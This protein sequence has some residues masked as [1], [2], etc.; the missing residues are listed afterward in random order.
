METKKLSEVM[1]NLG[2]PE[3]ETENCLK[4]IQECEAID[5]YDTNSCNPVQIICRVKHRKF[6]PAGDSV[7]EIIGTY[8]YDI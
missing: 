1:H 7:L 6:F 2:I 8:H 3:I 4:S 5:N